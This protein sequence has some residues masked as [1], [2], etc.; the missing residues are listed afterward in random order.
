M[1]CFSLSLFSF[2]AFLY[3]SMYFSDIVYMYVCYTRSTELLVHSRHG[4]SVI[5]DYKLTRF[6]ELPR[7]EK[8]GK[9]RDKNRKY[10]EGN[11]LQKAILEE[12]L[13]L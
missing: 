13:Q 5:T 10:G 2:F 7:K 6:S 1:I 11:V 12:I 3:K 9:W 8:M 4:K